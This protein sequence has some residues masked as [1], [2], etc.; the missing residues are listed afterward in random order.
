MGL[1]I[2]SFHF[3]NVG[4]IFRKQSDHTMA[5]MFTLQITDWQWKEIF[6]LSFQQ[7][8]ETGWTLSIWLNLWKFKAV[9]KRL[10]IEHSIHSFWNGGNCQTQQQ[11]QQK[12]SHNKRIRERI[13]A[14][15]CQKKSNN[16]VQILID[17]QS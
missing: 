15:W 16:A 10:N 6:I 14:G 9:W 8:S 11:Q 7:T 4:Y 1:M 2:T 5:V 17:W 13:K 3:L 12:C